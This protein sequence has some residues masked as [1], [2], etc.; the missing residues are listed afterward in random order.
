MAEVLTG[1][2]L[3]GRVRYRIEGPPKRVSHCHCEQCRRA[4]GGVALTLAAFDAGRV[5]FEGIAMKSVRPTDFATRRFCPECGSHIAFQ[6]DARPEDVAITVGTLDDPAQVPAI[7]HNF[8][9]EKI[10]WVRLDE[11]LPGAPRWWNPPPGHE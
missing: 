5:T 1:H 10:P 9:S 6:F 8:T 3:C 4:S 7:R 11:H 2:C